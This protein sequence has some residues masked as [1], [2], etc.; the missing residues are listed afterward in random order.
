M[1]ASKMV[2]LENNIKVRVNIRPFQSEQN[3]Q[4]FMNRIANRLHDF[5]Y[6]KNLKVW[7]VEYY[8]DTRKNRELLG[9][10]QHIPV[11][12]PNN[13]T[14]MIS[15]KQS[16]EALRRIFKKIEGNND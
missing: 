11:I 4:S 15:G 13:L 7:V 3:F 10:S 9:F 2:T 14:P 1:K 16:G 6:D 5:R 8:R 12:R